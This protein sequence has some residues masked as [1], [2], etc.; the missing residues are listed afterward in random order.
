VVLW[1]SFALLDVPPRLPSCPETTLETRVADPNFARKTVAAATSPDHIYTTSLSYIIVAITLDLISAYSLTVDFLT[2]GQS[3]S[4]PVSIPMNNSMSGPASQ[5]HCISPATRP[6]NLQVLEITS[7]SL[8]IAL[9]L[10][11]PPSS[12]SSQHAS[13]STAS[14]SGQAGSATKQRRPRHRIKNAHYESDDDLTAVEDNDTGGSEAQQVGQNSSSPSP[15]ASSTQS[16]AFPARLAPLPN[17]KPSFKELLSKG[18]MVTVNGRP[19][20]QIVAHVSDDEPATSGVDSNGL[21]SDSEA[22]SSRVVDKMLEQM[23]RDRAVVG[24]FGLEPGKEYEIDLKV[25]ANFAGEGEPLQAGK[26]PIV[27]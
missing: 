18:V 3:S 4:M 2:A 11:Q 15:Y 14:T 13:T 27:Y 7:I 26:F 1:V 12:R 25:V 24:I 6:L 5:W 20:N 9:S 23:T 10:A 19:W 22:L 17:A 8:T 16:G 21:S